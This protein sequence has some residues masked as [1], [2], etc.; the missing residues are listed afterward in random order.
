MLVHCFVMWLLLSLFVPVGRDVS[1]LFCDVVVAL[2]CM[3]VWVGDASSLF[4]DVVV[5]LIVCA[6]G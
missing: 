2:Y 4:C 3:Y 1:S 5:A 6:C